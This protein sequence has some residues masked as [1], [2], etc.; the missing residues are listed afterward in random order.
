[1]AEISL[2]KLLIFCSIDLKHFEPIKLKVSLVMCERHEGLPKIDLKHFEP[3]KLKVS[4]VMCERHE[5][6]PKL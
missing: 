3:I 4:L 1:V 6:L 2:N 5:G